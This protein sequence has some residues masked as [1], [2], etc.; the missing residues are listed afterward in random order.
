MVA[1]VSIYDQRDRE[2]GGG[3][4]GGREREAEGEGE[5]R[6]GRCNGQ[7]TRIRKSNLIRIQYNNNNFQQTLT[8]SIQTRLLSSLRNFNVLRRTSEM[9]EKSA[10][11]LLFSH[12]VT[13]EG[14]SSLMTRDMSSPEILKIQCPALLQQKILAT[15][16]FW[17]KMP[18]PVRRL[19][20]R[21]S[22]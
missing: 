9:Y 13:N 22:D 19:F 20:E 10:M 16:D 5:T 12:S 3:I 8:L 2:R 18:S 4:G 14:R 1:R 17:K 7:Q 15:V 21:Y 6:G 11:R